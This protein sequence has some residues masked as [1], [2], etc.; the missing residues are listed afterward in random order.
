VQPYKPVAGGPQANVEGFFDEQADTLLDDL[1]RIG[2]HQNM[3]SMENYYRV[4]FAKDS[5][6]RI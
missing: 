1:I 4:I 2:F 3:R 6:T 5:K